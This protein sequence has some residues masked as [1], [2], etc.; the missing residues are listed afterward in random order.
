ME[1]AS[2]KFYNNTIYLP[3]L[4]S[5]GIY[6]INGASNM[7]GIE[8]KNNIIDTNVLWPIKDESD[9]SWVHSNNVLYGPHRTEV[10]TTLSHTYT[11]ADVLTW[12]PTA[13]NSDPLFTNAPT[14]LSLQSASPA[15]NA[16]TNVGLTSDFAS[17]P[18]VGVPDIG[19]YEYQ[20]ITT[21]S[22]D[23]TPP[24]APTGLSVI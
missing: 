19:A 9:N 16:G 20:G 24:A 5:Y 3:T 4:Y 15:I 14:D 2:N 12:E 13:Q 6:M 18:I 17:N 8:F 11:K 7:S 1:A 22:S 21:S 10:V 23:T